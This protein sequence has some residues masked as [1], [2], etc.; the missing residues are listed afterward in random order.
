MIAGTSRYAAEEWLLE[1]L[2]FSGTVVELGAGHGLNFPHY[3]TTVTQVVDIEPEP[4]SV[5]RQ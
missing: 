2:S 1:G 3:P 4:T 5:P